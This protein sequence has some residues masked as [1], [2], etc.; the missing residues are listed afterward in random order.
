MPIVF[1]ETIQTVINLLTENAQLKQ[2]V[3]QL[4]AENAQLKQ[5]AEK[6]VKKPTE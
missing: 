3:E 1:E 6:V 5:E 4:T 2:K